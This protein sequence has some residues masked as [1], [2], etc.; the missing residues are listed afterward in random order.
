MMN[1]VFL[2][3]GSNGVINLASSDTRSLISS[4][5][6]INSTSSIQGGSIS[7]NG[8]QSAIVKT[9]SRGSLASSDMFASIFVTDS[10]SSINFNSQL[11][12]TLN[13]RGLV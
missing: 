10:E 13:N 2:N 3:V 12:V 1:V 8:G 7:L 4:S 11:S 5:T 9:C 6:F